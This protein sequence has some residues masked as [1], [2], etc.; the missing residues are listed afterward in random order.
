MVSTPLPGTERVVT[1]QNK[2]SE[3]LYPDTDLFK[4]NQHQ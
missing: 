3:S 4:E 2:L 1:A